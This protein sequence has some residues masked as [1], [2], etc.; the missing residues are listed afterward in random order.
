MGYHHGFWFWG[1]MGW[2][3][4]LLCLLLVAFIIWV[5]YRAGQGNKTGGSSPEEILRERFARGEIDRE[6]LDK[7]L[8]ELKGS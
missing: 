7:K 6:E 5:A 3:W 4:T 8:S 1:G 2:G